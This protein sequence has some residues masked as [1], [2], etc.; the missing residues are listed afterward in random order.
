M[1]GRDGEPGHVGAPGDSVRFVNNMMMSLLHYREHLVRM[2]CPVQLEEEEKKYI[3]CILYLSDDDTR[4][5][6]VLG[7]HLVTKDHLD[8]LLVYY[9]LLLIYFVL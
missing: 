2:V 5:Q 4:E 1:P 3:F 9:I 7:V 8:N 6:P